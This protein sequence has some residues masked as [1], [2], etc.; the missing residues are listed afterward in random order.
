MKSIL[1]TTHSPLAIPLPRGKKLHLGPGK[2]GEISGEAAAHPPL[3]KMVEAGQ[4]EV[5]DSAAGSTGHAAD[6]G[7]AHGS[8]P[9]HIP[10]AQAYR[11][12]DR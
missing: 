12:G 9:G 3:L 1:N 5:T 8:S 2:R 4:V 10:G 6:A 7:G 11:S